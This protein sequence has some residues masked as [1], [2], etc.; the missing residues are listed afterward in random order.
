MDEN[1]PFSMAQ[2][3]ANTE[4][5]R[6]EGEYSERNK[7]YYSHTKKK[8]VLLSFVVDCLLLLL[9]L[10]LHNEHNLYSYIHNFPYILSHS[11]FLCTVCIVV[12][13]CMESKIHYFSI[14]I[15]QFDYCCHLLLLLVKNV[16]NSG[17]YIILD[18][19]GELDA[20]LGN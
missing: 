18:G 3:M 17:K 2:R 13:N 9:L 12:Q 10:M 8:L 15:F 11:L 14:F 7:H 20:T 16:N 5:W 6:E 4:R 1:S 19:C